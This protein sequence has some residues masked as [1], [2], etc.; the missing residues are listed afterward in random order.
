MFGLPTYAVDTDV[1]VN[2]SVSVGPPVGAM[3]PLASSKLKLL[4]SA[5]VTLESGGLG[6][7]SLEFEAWDSKT[8]DT[9]LLTESELVVDNRVT[10]SMGTG[11]TSVALIS[12]PITSLGASF[13]QGGIALS[14]SGYDV[15]H[16]LRQ[17]MFLRTFS[18]K[19]EI[20]IAEE[21]CKE[22]EVP[23]SVAMGTAKAPPARDGVRQS[24]RQSDFEFIADQLDRV[25]FVLDA[26][27]D[28]AVIRPPTAKP[29]NPFSIKDYTPKTLSSFSATD[30]TVEQV[31][32][33]RVLGYDPRGSAKIEGTAGTVTGKGVSVITLHRDVATVEA[34]KRIAQSEL[35]RRLVKKL[36]ASANLRGDA[37]L[38]PGA[39][40]SVADVGPFSG[41]WRIAT[42]VHSWNPGAGYTTALT[43]EQEV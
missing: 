22:R 17:G 19:S 32:G 8:N 37:T 27:A 13:S 11:T 24:G 3:R 2:L 29:T 31:D 34:A 15:R 12:G 23:V 30:S 43:L 7:F 36:T 25:G 28:T 42:A 14:I 16:I 40:I 10:L 1:Q 38:I 39:W 21:I 6:S 5:S 20:E 33:V 4:N 18:Q 35:D 9:G 41:E 26:E